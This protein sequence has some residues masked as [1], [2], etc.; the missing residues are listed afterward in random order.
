MSNE[1]DSICLNRVFRKIEISCFY[2]ADR[3]SVSKIWLC[4]VEMITGETQSDQGVFSI[5]EDN[6]RYVSATCTEKPELYTEKDIHDSRTT[7]KSLTEDLS[8]E[9]IS[10]KTQGDQGVFSIG[11][12]NLLCV[13]ATCTEKPELYTEKDIHDSRTTNESLTEDLS[14]EMITGETQSDQGVFSIGEDNLRY[15]SATC[16]EKPELYTEKDI[17]DS[18][19]TNKSLTEDLSNEMI[20]G[21]TQGDQGV[22]SIGEDNLLCVSATCTEKPELYTEKYIHDSRTTN[23]SLTEDLSNEMITGETQSDQGVFSIGEDN[24]RYVS[25]T[26]TEKP[27]LYTEKDIHDSRTTNKSL[28]E[29]LSNEMISGKTQG[30]QGVFSIGEDNLLC[31]SATCTEKPELYTEKDIHDSRTTN[32]S[33]TEDLSNEMIT[34]ETQSDQGVFSIGEDNLRYVSATCTEKPELYTEKDIHDSRT[35]NKSLTEDLSNEMISGKT[36]GDQG[37]FSIGEDNLLCVSATC[38]EKPELY[39]EKYIHDS[40]TTNESL[41]EDLSNEMITGETQSDQGVFSIGED[42]LRYVSATCTEKPELYTEKDIHDSRTTNKSLTEDLSN[43]MISGKT[44]GDQGVFSIGE[45][46][47]LCVSATCTEKPE[48]YTEKYIHDSRTT[49]ESLTED[50]SNE[51][52]TD[53]TQSDQ[54]VFSIGEDNLR[55]VSATCTEKPELY[56]EKDIH[57]SRTTNESL[58]EDLS[59]DIE[60][61]PSDDDDDDD[62]SYVP[63]S[64]DYD[65]SSSDSVLYPEN[66]EFVKCKKPSLRSKKKLKL[67]VSKGRSHFTNGSKSVVHSKESVQINEELPS[68]GQS[69]D[70]VQINEKASSEGIHLHLK[71]LPKPGCKKRYDK[72]NFCT[73]CHKEI[74]SKISRHLLTHK[75]ELK[76]MEIQML[77]KKSEKRGMLFLELINEGNYKHNI[78]VLKNGG[79]FITARRESPD[80]SNH[81]PDEYLPCEFCKGFFLKNL[82]WHHA[83][84][85]KLASVKN[86]DDDEDEKENE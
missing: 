86:K 71:A 26:C 79:L 61:Y 15:V 50:L 60:M 31:V 35:T 77:P 76:I 6:L 24:L 36:Q 72:I 28:T 75:N 29:D 53:E 51:M 69:K 21:K 48:L 18:R 63:D 78:E 59:N 3:I 68:E 12:D 19:T 4:I 46:N 43:E 37:V 81:S 27:E 83:K 13:S 11:E 8:N 65:S 55:Y 10:G 70:S 32:E 64:E 14:N 67:E 5:G 34:G 17:H 23:E 85:C 1:P 82:L 30:D 7:N 22:F 33:L 84:S 45:D 49:N 44:Q 80:S 73:F 52:I 57:D 40:R 47:L 39:T 62:K 16:T 54:G 41:T 66:E 58:T 42:N 38:T 20:S 25:A 56:T 2:P 74:H 9:M